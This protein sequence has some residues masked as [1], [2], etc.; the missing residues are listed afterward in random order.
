MFLHAHTHF[1]SST[2]GNYLLPRMQCSSSSSQPVTRNLVNHSNVFR[3]CAVTSENHG[4]EDSGDSGSLTASSTPR[5]TNSAV[6]NGNHAAHLH[7]FESISDLLLK[8][9]KAPL[10]KEQWIQTVESR[11]EKA[12][13]D[14]RF[15]TLTAIVGSL[16]GSLLCFVKGC[17]FICESFISYFEMCLNG[18]HTGNVILRLVEAVDVYLVGT[19]MLIFG[20]GL[21]GLFISNESNDGKSDRALKNTTLFGMFALTRRPLWMRITT[22][23]TLK[24]K[25]GHVI[26]MIL[27]VKLFEKSKTVQIRSSMDLLCYSISIFLSS[28]SLFVLQR[29]HAS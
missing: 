9:A 2:R 4:F 5:L 27:L 1:L 28:A 18:L 15:L 7:E 24:T 21:Y 13:F 3:C 12:I 29:L 19:V 6:S 22:L 8:V 20:M 16:V 11:I 26:V 17:G 25:L 14:F 10:G 23:D